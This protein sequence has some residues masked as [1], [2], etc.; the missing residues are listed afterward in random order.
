MCEAR[1]TQNL[2]PGPPTGAA[3]EAPGDRERG[4]SPLGGGSPARSRGSGRMVERMGHGGPVEGSLW[5]S[6]WRARARC[7][8]STAGRLTSETEWLDATP[9]PL[10]AGAPRLDR[11]TSKT[12]P[13]LELRDSTRRHED[14]SETGTQRLEVSSR[15]PLRNRRGLRGTSSLETRRDAWNRVA[16]HGVWS[17]RGGAPGRR[18]A[19]ACLFRAQDAALEWTNRLLTRIQEVGRL[20]IA[21]GGAPETKRFQ[22]GVGPTQQVPLR[23]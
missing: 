15:R 6:G 16:A 2:N 8:R 9:R 3:A 11:T 4:L 13:N 1:C 14:N 20:R 5:L 12:T 23:N 17:R 21:R 7:S 10:E 19:A 22:R 18:W